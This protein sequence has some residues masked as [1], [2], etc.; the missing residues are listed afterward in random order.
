MLTLDLLVYKIFFIVVHHLRLGPKHRSFSLCWCFD[1][2]AYVFFLLV[3][4]QHVLG[5]GVLVEGV[6]II[7]GTILHV[8]KVEVIRVLQNCFRLPKCWQVAKLGQ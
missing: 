5:F 2:E 6:L 8:I 4:V 3:I 1:L 7:M